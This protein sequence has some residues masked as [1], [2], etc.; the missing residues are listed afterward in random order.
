MLTCSHWPGPWSSSVV[1]GLLFSNILLI[2]EKF[3]C[4]CTP[5][6]DRPLINTQSPWSYDVDCP[7]ICINGSRYS[8]HF[9]P[10][11]RSLVF[12]FHPWSSAFKSSSD[13]RKCSLH[14]PIDRP[15][16]N[17]Q[18]P[19]SYAVDCWLIRISDPQ[20]LT[21]SHQTGPW[22]SSIVPD[23]LLSN[24]PL[25]FEKFPCTSQLIDPW[26]ILNHRYLLIYPI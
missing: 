16:I 15:L 5:Q 20:P 23:L 22:S 17:P 14:S 2:F 11:T 4:T 19:W 13:F 8:Y 18:P 6:I 12:F 24:L 1:T 10:P 21:F 7:L 26:S 9:L 3:P 25:I